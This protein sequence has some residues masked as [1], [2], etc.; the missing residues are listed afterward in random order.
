M[1]IYVNGSKV[2]ESPLG[3]ATSSRDCLPFA[4]VIAGGP[5]DVNGTQFPTYNPYSGYSGDAVQNLGMPATLCKA[6]R[7]RN[8]EVEFG[9]A[10]GTA[11]DS[12]TAA[13]AMDNI[14]LVVGDGR[15]EYP[16]VS[17]NGEPQ[18]WVR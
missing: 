10:G 11:D 2:G 16:D 1:A 15:S 9:C 18:A 4:Q 5:Y 8:T 17:S 13:G 12:V 3:S 6:Y 7:I 14:L